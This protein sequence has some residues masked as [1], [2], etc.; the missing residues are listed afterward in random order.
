ME[1]ARITLDG[2]HWFNYDEWCIESAWYGNKQPL[3]NLILSY[4]KLSVNNNDMLKLNR[5]VLIDWYNELTNGYYV[6]KG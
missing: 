4:Y 1:K 5:N 2:T 3:I 6:Y